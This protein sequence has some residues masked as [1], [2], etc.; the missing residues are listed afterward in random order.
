MSLKE[1]LRDDLN[2]ARRAR[3][4]ERTLIL[5]TT[6]SEVRNREIEM[7]RDASDE[8][9]HEVVQRAVKRR[10]EA[11]EQMRAGEREDLAAREDAE[12]ALLGKYLPAQ[13][14]EEEVRGYVREAIAGGADN[15]GAVMGR[16]MPRIKGVFDGKEANRIVKEELEKR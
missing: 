8:D 13:L 11:A 5:T 10:R 4:K 9:V 16:V 3:D 2:T 1:E 15:I 12:A 6:L 14:S 7:G